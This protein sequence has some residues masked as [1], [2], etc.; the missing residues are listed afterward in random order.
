[1][2]FKNKYSKDAVFNFKNVPYQCINFLFDTQDNKEL[3]DFLL[4]NNNFI[5][6]Q[7]EKKN[8]IEK[9]VISKPKKGGA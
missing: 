6:E 7:K 5:S 8:D 2:I 4:A 9:E 1:M 3:H